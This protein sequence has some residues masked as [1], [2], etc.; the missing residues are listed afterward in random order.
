MVF[1]ALSSL[2]DSNCSD[3]GAIVNFIEQKHE[4]PKNFRRMI[5]A[6]LKR[7][8]AQGK[9]ERVADNYIISQETSPGTKLPTPKPK[10]LKPQNPALITCEA[11]AD[12]AAAAAYKVAEAENRMFQ[13]EQAVKEAERIAVMA[14]HAEATLQFVKEIYEQCSRGEVVLLA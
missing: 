2:K 14:E 3:L 11:M 6:N 13:A 4:V 1:E 7:L 12:A 9:V 8:V 10:K 5:S